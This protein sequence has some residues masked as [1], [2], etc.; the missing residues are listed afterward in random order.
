MSDLKTV[1]VSVVVLLHIFLQ[2]TVRA[3]P[4]IGFSSAGDSC[5]QVEKEW[6]FQIVDNMRVQ[7]ALDSERQTEENQRLKEENERLR[8]SIKPGIRRYLLLFLVKRQT[9]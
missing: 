3:Q 7:C 4:T 2:S 5:S 1:A 8:L 9:D 6:R